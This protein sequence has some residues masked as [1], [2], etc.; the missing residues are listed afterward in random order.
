LSRRGQYARPPSRVIVA[1]RN[2]LPARVD[3][4]TGIVPRAAKAIFGSRAVLAP[5]RWFAD[6]AK[7]PRHGAATTHPTERLAPARVLWPASPRWTGSHFRTA[8]G[9]AVDAGPRFRRPTV[10]G[11]DVA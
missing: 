6:A 11:L 2:G 8:P 5:F 1:A 7:R 10:F 3:S 9:R 4:W